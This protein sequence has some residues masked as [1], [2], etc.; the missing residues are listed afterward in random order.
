[1]AHVVETPEKVVVITGPSFSQGVKFILFGAA[2][3]AG[4]TF[5]YLGKRPK[6]S[7]GASKPTNATQ[8]EA[9][10]EIESQAVSL[11]ARLKD[12]GEKA[13]DVA[14]IAGENL[15]PALDRAVEEGKKTAADVQAKLKKEL[16]EAGDKPHFTEE[17]LPSQS[18]EKFVE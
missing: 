12:L 4:A 11:L 3:G 2:L 6:T 7:F 16:D 18:E 17:D 15:K 1:M 5:Y 9:A 14:V 8:S 13:R 10:D